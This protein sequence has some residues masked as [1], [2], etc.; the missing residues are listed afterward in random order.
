MAS[1][2]EISA[3]KIDIIQRGGRKKDFWDVHELLNRFSLNRMLEFHRLR[4]PFSHDRDEILENFMNISNADSDFDPI[5]L[6][7]KYWEIIKNELTLEA[8]SM[9]T[10]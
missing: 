8:T 6:R 7:G 3:M 2:E 10:E 1:P 9:L 4:Y 5:C